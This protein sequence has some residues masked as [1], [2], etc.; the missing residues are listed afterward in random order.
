MLSRGVWSLSIA[1]HRPKG[2]VSFDVGLTN[3]STG[4]ADANLTFL[5]VLRGGPVNRGDGLVDTLLK[6][7]EAN[8]KF[9]AASTSAN[10]D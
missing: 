2:L 4:A 3:G 10:T 9:I 7:T 8:E 5:L 1:K 6:Y